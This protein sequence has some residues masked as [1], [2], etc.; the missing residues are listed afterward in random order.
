[1]DKIME[2]RLWKA[3]NSENLEENE[4]L[5]K[6]IYELKDQKGWSQREVYQLYMDFLNQVVERG[7]EEQDDYLRCVLDEIVGWCSGHRAIWDT[8]LK[9]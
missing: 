4:T 1:M 2:E 7:T 5:H 3:L 6:I 9:T 8:Y